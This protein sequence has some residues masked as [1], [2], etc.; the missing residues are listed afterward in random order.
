MPTFD[1]NGMFRAETSARQSAPSA[2][3][4]PRITATRFVVGGFARGAEF[5][6][7]QTERRAAELLE[8]S[9]YGRES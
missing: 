5:A 3:A 9:P 7:E 4:A 8:C 6:G 2:V 1:V